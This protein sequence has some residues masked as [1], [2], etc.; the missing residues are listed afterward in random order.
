MT[1]SHGFHLRCLL[2]SY[3][4]HASWPFIHTLWWN[5]FRPLVGFVC[6]Y[7]CVWLGFLFW[8]PFHVYGWLEVP[9]DLLPHSHLT[10]VVAVVCREGWY[11]LGLIPGGGPGVHDLLDKDG[12]QLSGRKC[13]PRSEPE[14]WRVVPAVRMCEPLQETTVQ[15]IRDCASL[16]FFPLC[17]L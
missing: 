10:T 13:I 12:C 17:R 5:E 8:A 7:V 6:V 14:P 4:S 2:M 3:L 1:A 9:G 15:V 16:W 11:V